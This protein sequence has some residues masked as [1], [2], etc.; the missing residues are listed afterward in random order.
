MSVP[1]GRLAELVGASCSGSVAVQ[2][3]SAD[4]RTCRP[5]DLFICMPSTRRDTHDL[6]PEAVRA[7]AV[8][9][10]VRSADGAASA[11]NLGMA[12]V[13][14]DR[15]VPGFCFAIGLMCREV[16]GDPTR[17]LRVMGVTGTNGKTTV[18]WMIKHA[19]DALGV[20]CAYLGT[21]GYLCGETVEEVGNT[22]PFP[23]ELWGYLARARESGVQAICLE[24]S[25]HALFERRLAGVRFDCGVFTNLTQDHLDFHG[26]MDRYA[27]AKK[28]LF[29][30]YVAASSKPFVGCLNAD[31]A[32]GVSWR[33][34]VP[35]PVVTYGGHGDLSV[36][37]LNEDLGSLEIRVT[38]DGR[39]CTMKLGLGGRFNVANSAAALSALLGL[40]YRLEEG[41]SALEQVPPVPGRFEVV[42]GVSVNVLVDYAHT[43]DA[44]EKL[45]RSVR[46]LCKGRLITVFGCGGDR[47]KT[48][49]PLMARVASQL[50]D[51]V[52]ATSDNPRTEDP[53][54]ILREIVDS[55][56]GDCE[57]ILDRGEA[58][59]QAVRMASRDDVVVVAG[60]GHEN[61][62]IIGTVKYPMDDRELVRSALA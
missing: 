22:T 19:L 29:T 24:A 59:R 56:S 1:L 23:A 38:F 39:S 49:R 28:L 50:S 21:L 36:E 25:S 34:E 9:A 30:E 26:T 44:L 46:P 62:Q 57:G 4:T 16:Y 33:E 35:C 12:T 20:P 54:A 45:L 43:P 53:E 11:Q 5:G 37:L 55:C 18:T 13:T 42:D 31:D 40:G 6:L 15:T 52:V 3:V 41:A 58:I 51:K 14:V 2:G 32:T 61:Y 27:D 7:G 17:D 48:K 60:K 8:A 47:D 10:V